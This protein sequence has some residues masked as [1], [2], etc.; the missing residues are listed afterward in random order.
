MAR[1][2]AVKVEA[3]PRLNA[4]NEALKF[5]KD[6]M[7]VGL[8]SGTTANLFIAELGK[9]I[10]EEGLNVF[11]VPTSFESRMMAI[12][13]GIPLVS[14]DEYGELDIAVDGADEVNKETLNVIK[15]GGG[16]HTQEKIIDYCAKELIIIVDESKL[17]DSL[18]ENTPVPLEVLPFAYSSVLNELL[19]M[20]SAPSI[21]MADKKMG[22][23]ITDNGNM[24]IDVFID[25]NNP[26]E[27]EKQLNNIPGV[28]ENGIFTKVDKVIVGKS[29]KAEILKK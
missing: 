3:D 29:D 11:G 4:V 27:V 1:K 25:L 22:P 14:L 21:R 7:I 16:C 20:N 19:K 2:K 5:I 8:G 15:G 9:K 10:S 17:V 6:G 12:Q 13:Y 24:I 23:V 26:E 18:G 28:V